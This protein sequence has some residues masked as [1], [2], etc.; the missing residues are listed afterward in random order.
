EKPASEQAATLTAIAAAST[1]AATPTT[2]ATPSVPAT[3]TATASVTPTGVHTSTPGATATGTAVSLAASATASPIRSVLGRS[4]AP[5][6]PTPAR[7]VVTLPATGNG[8][9]AAGVA[10]AWL[11]LASGAFAILG[12]AAIRRG[13]AVLATLRG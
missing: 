12:A 11:L 8:P 7:P 4:A 1:K 6:L 3:S 2:T 5:L 13:A 10:T 9:P